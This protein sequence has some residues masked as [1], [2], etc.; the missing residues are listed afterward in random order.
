MFKN[1]PFFYCIKNSK[2][3]FLNKLNNC[4]ETVQQ[5]LK[6]AVKKNRGFSVPKIKRFNQKSPLHIQL[7][8]IEK[9]VIL[10]IV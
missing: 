2:Y 1:I 5:V 3:F 7:F 9:M 4:I 6:N 8:L 10:A